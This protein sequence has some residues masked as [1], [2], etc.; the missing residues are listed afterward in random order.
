MSSRS[1]AVPGGPVESAT[2]G[3][4]WRALAERREYADLFS[5]ALHESGLVDRELLL[6][7][8]ERSLTN[9]LHV[10]EV[11]LGRLRRKLD[12]DSSLHPIDTLRG[13]GYRMV[14]D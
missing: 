11:L 1:L 3:P 7:R 14:R 10:L 13:R 5:R 4:P 12:P 6:A 8:S 2:G 9:Y